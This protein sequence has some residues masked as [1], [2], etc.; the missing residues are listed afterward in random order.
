MKI[1]NSI[2][3]LLILFSA[4][5]FF[6]TTYSQCVS[7]ESHVYPFSYNS[8]NYEVVKEK[9]N[10]TDAAACAASRGGFLAEI[11]SQ[12]EQDA[13]FSNVNNAG[14]NASNTV[15]SDG[16]GA[17]Y[18]WLGGNDL[19]TE[20]VWIWDGNNDGTFTQFWQ[21]GVNG[22][23][24]NGSYNNWGHE[25]D[26]WNNIQ[27]ALGLA[28]TEWPLGSGS[29]GSPGQWNDVDATNSLYYIIEYPPG[30]G[31]E[32][33]KP[34]GIKISPN[35]SSGNIIITASGNPDSAFNIKIYSLTGMLVKEI[36]ANDLE[37]HVDVSNLPNGV[38]V[39]ALKTDHKIS[40][41]SKLIIKK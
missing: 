37:T 35:P 40:A 18:L 23:P 24:V 2:Q 21:G 3:S 33:N 10:W 38:Y 14:I 8:I 7:D 16:G 15:A 29:L 13:I 6:Q 25:P 1:K 22:N 4:I 41:I 9:L 36:D 31:I 12:T 5:S 26:N 27:D 11:N 19:A 28:V 39:V 34:T 20:G 32:K 17:S 30:A